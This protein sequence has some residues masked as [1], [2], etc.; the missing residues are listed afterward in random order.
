MSGGVEEEEEKDN[1]DGDEDMTTGASNHV[2]ERSEAGTRA[3]TG[4]RNSS[5]RSSPVRKGRDGWAGP[6]VAEG[7]GWIEAGWEALTLFAIHT[8][9]HIYIYTHTSVCLSLSVGMAG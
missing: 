7:E 4:S 1:D 3:C 2:R 6:S 8:Y 5:T 9:I